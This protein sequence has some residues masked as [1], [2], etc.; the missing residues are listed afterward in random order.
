MNIRGLEEASWFRASVLAEK[1][2]IPI[3]NARLLKSGGITGVDDDKAHRMIE[4]G[5]AES[6]AHRMIEDGL[7]ES[8]DPVAEIDEEDKDKEKEDL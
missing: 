7:A 2:G 3:D 4:D 1:Y 6:K 8:L 5:L